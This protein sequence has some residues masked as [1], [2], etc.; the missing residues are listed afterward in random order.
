MAHAVIFGCETDRQ[1]AVVTSRNLYIVA[2]TQQHS[3]HAD[4]TVFCSFAISN[5]LIK[6]HFTSKISLWLCIAS[7]YSIIF[8][9][10]R[11]EVTPKFRLPMHWYTDYSTQ[12]S[13]T[14]SCIAE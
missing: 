6:I 9:S 2:A 13:Q 8:L 3:T 12:L 4:H 7:Q 1:L 5:I 14:W 11:A 10:W